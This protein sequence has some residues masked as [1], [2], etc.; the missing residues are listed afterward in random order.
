MLWA[1]LPLLTGYRVDRDGAEGRI[2][3]QRD[4]AAA[5]H[6]TPPSR[7]AAAQLAYSV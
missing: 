4:L 5:H 3:R 6:P 2:T 1:L 7:L